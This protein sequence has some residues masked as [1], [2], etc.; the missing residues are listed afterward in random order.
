M[1][2]LTSPRHTPTLREA[3]AR[4]G[5][6]DDVPRF[7]INPA[8]RRSLLRFGLLRQLQ[9][10]F[11]LDT[12]VANRAFELR[13]PKSP[14]GAAPRAAT[15]FVGRSERAWCE[16]RVLSGAQFGRHT[17]AT[18]KGKS[19]DARPPDPVGQSG[20]CRLSDLELRRS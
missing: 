14:R 7:A 10:V 5:E 2:S 15:W 16:P 13:G 18:W 8:P 20:P 19:A 4:L 12:E 6:P 11:Y 1:P 17:N 9:S 3:A